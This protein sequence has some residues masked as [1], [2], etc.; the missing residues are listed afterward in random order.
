MG[1]GVSGAC[2]RVRG[3]RLESGD[4]G[5]A[6]SRGARVPPRWGVGVELVGG[7]GYTARAG[8]GEALSGRVAAGNKRK[9]SGVAGV[10]LKFFLTQARFGTSLFLDQVRARLD[11]AKG[12][13]KSCPKIEWTLL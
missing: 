1:E 11:Q 13:S 6:R 12:I 7:A 10:T 3:R 8:T 9:R 5:V 2:V 4:D